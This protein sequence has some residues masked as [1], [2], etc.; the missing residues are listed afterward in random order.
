MTLSPLQRHTCDRLAVEPVPPASRSIVGI[1]L[2]RPHELEPLQ[3]LRHPVAGESNGWFV[4]RGPAIPQD[5]DDFFV[6]LHVEHLADREPDLVPYLALPPGW[7]VI[8]AAGHEDVW[9]DERLLDV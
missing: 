6:A 3:A 8:L 5:D 9:F 1:A 2:S 4:W 7:G